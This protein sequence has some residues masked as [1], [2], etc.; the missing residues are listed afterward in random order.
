MRKVYA[1]ALLH[2]ELLIYGFDVYCGLL[3]QVDRQVSGNFLALFFVSFS[4]KIVLHLLSR[5]A[6][7]K[8]LI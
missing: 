1:C 3:K 2:S 5:M 6:T 4:E 7:I 8:H